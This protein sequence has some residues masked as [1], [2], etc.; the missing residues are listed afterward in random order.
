LPAWDT[1]TAGRFG[2]LLALAALVGALVPAW[3]AARAMPAEL[4]GRE[5][6]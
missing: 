3:Q 5:G 4:V 6:L 1:G 2:L